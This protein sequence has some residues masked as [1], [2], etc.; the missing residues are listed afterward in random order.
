MLIASLERQSR[1]NEHR[2]AKRR[3]IST[4]LGGLAA[5]G[6]QPRAGGPAGGGVP[7]YHLVLLRH[8]VGQLAEDATQLTDRRLHLL[9]VIRTLLEVV[10][11]LH[12]HELVL[13]FEGVAEAAGAV[14][15]AFALAAALRSRGGEDVR[16]HCHEQR[17]ARVLSVP[18]L[19]LGGSGV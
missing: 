7:M 11:W 18:Q 15:A 8:D 1:A 9:H 2:P 6:C 4:V 17:L 10:L 19:W 13:R 3:S 12:R 5:A 14:R 16:A